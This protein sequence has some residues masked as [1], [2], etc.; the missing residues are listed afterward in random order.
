MSKQSRILYTKPS[1]TELETRYAADAAANG[2][3][4]RCYDYINRFEAA[5]RDHLGVSHAIATSSCTGALHMGMAALDIGPGD[6]VIMADTN[7][8]AS[9]API[10]HLGA[11]PV[12]VDIRPDSWCIDPDLVEAAVT[13]RTKAILAVH[14]YGNLCDMDRLLAIG[15]R[16]G[17][18]V[19]EDAAE[20]IGSEYFDRR[21]GSM[22][23]FGA[24]SFHGTKTVT[25]GEG[26][27]F[28]TNDPSL[29]ERV[30]TLSNHGRSRRQRKQFWPDEVGFKYK[31]SNIQAALGCAQMDRVADLIGR[32]R[33][34][35]HYYRDR[36]RDLPGVRMNPEPSNI[37]NGAWM[38]TVVFDESTGVSREK[39]AAAFS[40]DNIDARVFFYPLSGLAMFDAVPGNRHA[41]SIPERA[42][43]L[44]SYH[45]MTQ[46]E[47]DRVI[48]VVRRVLLDN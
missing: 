12:F 35:F 45:D 29:Y 3:G 24:F 23:R 48:A 31:M 17:I 26:G 10:T 7:W 47:Q 18:P 39:L 9:A 25:T 38:P 33:Q 41:W 8:I 28:V 30:L 46:E 15:E 44:P 37:V 34:I 4:E 42:I 14:L 32:K 22:G 21:A 13:P 6:E 16:H 5:F 2:W 20:A 1:I 43:N 27:M 40:A 36:L 19:I 11:T